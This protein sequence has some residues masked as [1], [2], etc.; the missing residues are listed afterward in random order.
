MNCTKCGHVYSEQ[1]NYCPKCGNKL[2]SASSVSEEDIKNEAA[3][4][5][6]TNSIDTPD[7]VQLVA[8]PNTLGFRLKAKIRSW[9]KSLHWFTKICIFSLLFAS[10]LLAITF[11]TERR[12]AIFLSSF[13]LVFILVSWLIH[14]KILDAANESLKYVILLLSFVCIALSIRNLTVKHPVETKRDIQV[15]IPAPVVS[16]P[17]EPSKEEIRIKYS[18]D[19]FIG[20][21][22]NEVKNELKEL[23]FNN[24]DFIPIQDIESSEGLKDNNKVASIFVS[25]DSDFSDILQYQKTANIKVEFHSIKEVALSYS[26]DYLNSLSPGNAKEL[27][28]E[29]GFFNI[30][31]QI[32]E[33][34]L[35]FSSEDYSETEILIGKDS[36]FTADTPYP[37]DTNI[38][39]TS[40]VPNLNSSLKVRV[41]FIPNLLFS[42]YDVKVEFDDEYDRLK[43]G[44]DKE[45][46]Y[47]IKNG[48]HNLILSCDRDSDISTTIPIEVYGNT[49]FQ[50]QIKCHS[51][52]IDYEILSFDNEQPLADNEARLTTSKY[53]LIGQKREDVHEQLEKMGFTNITEEI[54]Y[55]ISSSASYEGDVNAITVNGQNSYVPG[56]IFK[57]DV[58]I[59]I[60]Y[61]MLEAND[62]QRKE[63]GSS[64]GGDSSDI[65][66][67]E[68]TNSL[69]IISKAH[70]L[71]LK[72]MITEDFGK[73]TTHVEYSTSDYGLHL[74]YTVSNDTAEVL[75]ARVLTF[76]KLYT[77]QEQADFI[78]ALA[79]VLCPTDDIDDVIKWLNDNLGNEAETVINGT[80]YSLCF[81]PDK[82]MIYEVGLPEWE[83][84]DAQ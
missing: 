45:L 9:W 83:K 61:R 76:S 42:T 22:C 49:D 73:N 50:M 18:S 44:T 70:D 52:Y 24:I 8:P 48:V 60:T 65:P 16:A 71:G 81:G 55:D 10:I 41:H 11:L 21:D 27:L 80:T 26:S 51:T 57:K 43:H 69:I 64:A 67:L 68:G 15:S 29:L 36:D 5:N 12:M 33:D 59:I 13:S 84:W 63:L 77:P 58:P 23:N 72:R 34:L 38:T 32:S 37:L 30:S 28:S 19:Y 40:H 78:A 25:E 4:D 17:A 2:I 35:D 66:T 7:T 39:I 62:P 31:C 82:N 14:K 75:N 53:S 74:E 46:N 56:E 1:I 20:K 6:K 54:V 3:C 79:P 47:S